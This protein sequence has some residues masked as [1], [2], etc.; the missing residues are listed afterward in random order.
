MPRELMIKEA[1]LVANS[2]KYNLKLIKKYPEKMAPGSHGDAEVFLRNMIRFAK[3]EKKNSRPARRLHV[4]LMKKLNSI[5]PANR[6][7]FK[8]V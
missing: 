5:I 4:V 2:A 1:L 7:S 8:S 3:N 6:R